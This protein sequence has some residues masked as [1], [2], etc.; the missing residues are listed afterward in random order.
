MF[1]MDHKFLLFDNKSCVC[2]LIPTSELKKDEREW[3]ITLSDRIGIQF[4]KMLAVFIS[5]LQNT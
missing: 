5:P 3:L 4:E 2:T 1:R